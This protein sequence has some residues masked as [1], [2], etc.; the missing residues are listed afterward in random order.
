MAMKPS[1]TDQKLR[2]QRLIFYED[3]IERINKADAKGNRLVRIHGVGFPQTYLA[4]PQVTPSAVAFANLM[5][6]LTWR[7]GGTFVGLIPPTL[8]VSLGGGG[9]LS[10]VL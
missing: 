5:R 7:N 4:Q 8:V 9:V 1:E 10:G 6:Q 3:D 2:K